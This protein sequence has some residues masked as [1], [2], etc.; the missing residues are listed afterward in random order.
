M[1]EKVRTPADVIMTFF[2]KGQLHRYL[3]I[4]NA[5]RSAGFGIEVYPDPKK[6]GQQLK[7]ADQ[8]GFTLALIAGEDELA[9]NAC[10]LKD[11]RTGESSTHSLEDNCSEL[12][13]AITTA[14]G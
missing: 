2:D 11:L 1:I 13:E 10:Q 14:L 8:R 5:V 7:Y 9:Q 4:A 6:L 3:D 12:I